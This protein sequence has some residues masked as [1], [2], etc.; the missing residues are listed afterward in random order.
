[1]LS[2]TG[3]PREVTV[4]PHMP[5]F[6]QFQWV[7]YKKWQ[8]EWEAQTG[9]AMP[10]DTIHLRKILSGV[11]SWTCE[12]KGNDRADTIDWREKQPSQAI[13]NQTLEL[14]QGQ[15]HWGNR[16]WERDGVERIWA[17][18]SAYNIIP[19]WTELN[20][21]YICLWTVHLEDRRRSRLAWRRL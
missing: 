15:H 7:C 11:L 12:V 19:S 13:V 10:F 21:W 4:R 1:M 16:S 20:C 8:V 17:F 3:V 6:S 9:M 5:S 2:A 18:P 14:F